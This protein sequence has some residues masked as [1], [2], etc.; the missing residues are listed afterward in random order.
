MNCS[1]NVELLPKLDEII[2]KPAELC[3]VDWALR[4]ADVARLN[5]CGKSVMCRDGM[6][7]L[8]TIIRDI[9]T[10]KGQSEDLELLRDI[11]GVIK[12]SEGCGIAMRAAALIDESITRYSDE[13][14]THI[15]RK[16]CTALVCRKYYTV[17]VLPEKC[18][19]AGACMKACRYGAIAGGDGLVSVLDNDKC[20]RC[21]DCFTV[22]PSGAIVKAGAVK[23]RAPESPVP[24]GGQPPAEEGDGGMRRRKRKSADTEE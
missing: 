9:T 13:W 17:H 7:Q 12:T 4:I 14:D 2:N 23:P 15:R 1:L 16:R 10:E 24:I 6:N 3:P 20:R 18:K 19:G 5:N 21:G 11:C 22:C 8:Y